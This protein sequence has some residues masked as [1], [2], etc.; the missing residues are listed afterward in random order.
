MVGEKTVL[1]PR[2]IVFAETVILIE[3]TDLGGGLT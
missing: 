2:Q 1:Q 3:N